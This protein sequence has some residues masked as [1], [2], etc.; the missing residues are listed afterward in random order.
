MLFWFS[1]LFSSKFFFYM[2]FPILNTCLRNQ[3]LFAFC[4]P[5][6]GDFDDTL[7]PVSVKR[8]NEVFLS[9]SHYAVS[10]EHVKEGQRGWGKSKTLE[11]STFDSVRPSTHFFP[12]F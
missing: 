2:G 11:L 8:K 4:P 5:A 1:S 7:L 6:K 12:E 10:G 9:P 3:A